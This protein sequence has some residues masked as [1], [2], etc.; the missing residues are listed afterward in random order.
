MADVASTPPVVAGAGKAARGHAA[1]DRARSWSRVIRGWL[2]QLIR[3]RS[4]EAA[5]TRIL[6]AVDSLSGADA[7]GVFERWV[8]ELLAARGWRVTLADCAG[9]P[10]A[11]LVA[12]V[13]RRTIVVRC[14]LAVDGPLDS[15]TV[16]A[17]GMAAGW[18]RS[19]RALIISNLIASPAVISWARACGV[20]LWDRPP[21]PPAIPCTATGTR[22]PRSGLASSGAARWP[23]LWSP[24]L[25]LKRS[26]R[27]SPSIRH[28]VR[29]APRITLWPHDGP[30]V[31][32]ATGQR[33]HPT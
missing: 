27:C 7:Q 31:R 13:G 1:I 6:A 5:A 14:R 3:L 22:R 18:Y 26:G 9:H 25:S 28:S 20:D 12:T 29:Q 16:E 33:S 21:M 17:I 11:D 4:R 24:A 30:A 10:P 2:T 23:A 32:W 19:T 8:A 15:R